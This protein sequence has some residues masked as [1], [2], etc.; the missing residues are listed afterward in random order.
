VAPPGWTGC[1]INEGARSGSLLFDLG[2][3]EIRLRGSG[4]DIWDTTDG[5]YY[6]HQAVT[7]D[8]QVRVKMLTR[9]TG[10][11]PHAKAG[12]MIRD[13]LEAGARH[14]SLLIH[15]RRSGLAFQWRH[16]ANDYPGTAGRS[17]VVRSA[18]LLLP[19]T[20]RLTRRGSTVIPEY[21]SDDG[22]SYQPAGLP[23][24]FGDPLPKTVYV[25]LAITAHAPGRI[26]EARFR[27]LSFQQ[28][29]SSSTAAP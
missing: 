17:S 22:R 28:R 10:T 21:S 24:T 2:S 23:I 7:D 9:P 5:F 4:A 3:G 26:S 12:L 20:L 14:A 18:A 25:G 6:L 8:V 19:I 15:H 13:S 27:D 29:R 16:R 11:S 1:S